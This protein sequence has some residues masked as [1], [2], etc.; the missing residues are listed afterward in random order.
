MRRIAL[1]LGGLLLCAGCSQ[2]STEPAP[3]RQADLMR[4]VDDALKLRD[5]TDRDTLL[6]HIATEACKEG[7]PEAV[8]ASIDLMYQRSIKDTTAGRCA[9]K[10]AY[11]GRRNEA[12]A[13]AH[14]I[15]D[16]DARRQ[17]IRQLP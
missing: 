7:S 3:P 17:V 1:L 10:L 13:I 4:R 8:V 9:L 15:G 6:A 11:L 12:H 14:R 16:D 5:Q 2:R